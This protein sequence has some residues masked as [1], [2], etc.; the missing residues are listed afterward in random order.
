MRTLPAFRPARV[1]R[2]TRG[3]SSGKTPKPS[4]KVAN[5][6]KSAGDWHLIRP[7]FLRLFTVPKKKGEAS[8]FPFPLESG[9]GDESRTRDLNLGKVALYQLSYSRMRPA[10]DLNYT[11]TF[12]SVKKFRAKL[13]KYRIHGI[14]PS[15]YAFSSRK[16]APSSAAL[17]SPIQ[18]SPVTTVRSASSRF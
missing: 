10:K 15:F 6:S 17:R 1:S 9:A 16:T 14:R 13:K 3:G 7:I 18:F 8:R 2:T 5:F 11:E 4:W 12:R